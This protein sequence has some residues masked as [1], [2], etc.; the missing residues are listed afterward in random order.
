MIT[1][2]KINVVAP[3]V[4]YRHFYCIFGRR[5]EGITLISKDQLRAELTK[6]DII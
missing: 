4:P 1:L 2:A 3:G 5:A 6:P